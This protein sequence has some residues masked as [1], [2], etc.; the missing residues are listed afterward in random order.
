MER[1]AVHELHRDATYRLYQLTRL[2][3][4]TG[5]ASS[6]GQFFATAEP[7]AVV[8]RDSIGVRALAADG[9][10]ISLAELAGACPGLDRLLGGSTRGEA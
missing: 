6:G 3:V 7:L 1:L 2:E 9:T 5:C 10:P 4:Q 8:V